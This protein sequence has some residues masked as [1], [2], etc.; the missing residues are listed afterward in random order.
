MPGSLAA[1]LPWL[2]FGPESKI[3]GIDSF[4]LMGER[5][6]G[7]TWIGSLLTH[8]FYLRLHEDQCPNKHDFDLS[9]PNEFLYPESN[10]LV[11]GVVR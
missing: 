1:R 2:Q 3:P 9:V 4:C 8:N 5:T 6:S 7:T 11:V 10:V